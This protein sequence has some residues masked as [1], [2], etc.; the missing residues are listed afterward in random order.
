MKNL[1]H[2]LTVSDVIAFFDRFHQFASSKEGMIKCFV[3]LLLIALVSVL[4]INWRIEMKRKVSLTFTAVLLA[5]LTLFDFYPSTKKV[6]LTPDQISQRKGTQKQLEI[7]MEPTISKKSELRFKS[8]DE[9]IAYVE[10]GVLKCVNDGECFL[11]AYDVK[12]GVKSNRIKVQVVEPRKEEKAESKTEF[13]DS[14]VV[15]VTKSGKKYHTADC[16]F[17]KK[18]KLAVTKR[19]AEQSGKTPCTKCGA[20]K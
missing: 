1:K 19:E 14:D 10:G 15:Y 18:T 17:L 9:N 6:T 3:I 4:W 8:S 13:K 11:Y 7:V 2:Y 12:S 16:S 20:S 5:V